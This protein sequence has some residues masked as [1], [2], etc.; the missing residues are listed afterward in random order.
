MNFIEIQSWPEVPQ[1]GFFT[2]LFSSAFGLP[3]F[4]IEVCVAIKKYIFLC[5]LSYV[6]K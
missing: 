4:D 5:H 2:S 1:I 3:E 6:V